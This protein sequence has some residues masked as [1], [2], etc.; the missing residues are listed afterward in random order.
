V[1]TAAEEIVEFERSVSA[2]EREAAL[3]R[4]HNRSNYEPATEYT[5]LD[6][7][8]SREPPELDGLSE[9]ELVDRLEKSGLTLS[10]VPPKRDLIALLHAFTSNEHAARLE[11]C[12]RLL[13]F[14]AAERS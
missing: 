3:K 6:S 12:N 1:K 4:F 2:R 14:F 8:I 10:T 7:I 13:A 9:D 5:P 11:T